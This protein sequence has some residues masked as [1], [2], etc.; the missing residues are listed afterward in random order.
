MDG[1][2][3]DRRQ[4]A[5]GEWTCTVAIQVPASAVAPVEGETYGL[6]STWRPWIL[7]TRWMGRPGILHA[8]GCP[9]AS[10]PHG[11][12]VRGLTT[13]QARDHLAAEPGTVRCDLCRPE[14]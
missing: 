13:A 6:V 11:L 10:G 8:A 14:P 4:D 9:S 5:A 2:L 1:R 7:H 3:L 12:Y